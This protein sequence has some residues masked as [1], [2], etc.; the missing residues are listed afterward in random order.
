MQT[1]QTP[2]DAKI[3]LKSYDKHVKPTLEY[4]KEGLGKLF[5]AAMAKFPDRIGC[6]FMENEMTFR[7]LREKIHRFAT[8]LQQNG[9]GKGER[10]AINLPN[11]PQYLIAHFGTL[12]AGGVASGCSPLMSAS[13]IAYQI[14]DSEAKFFVTLDAFY[15]KVLYQV[16]GKMPGL[17][18]IITTNISE[19]MDLSKIL[20][21]LGKLLGKIPKGKVKPFPDKNVMDFMQ[22]MDTEINLTEVNIN[23]DNDLA[24]LQYTGGTT[25]LPKGTELTHSNIIS[26]IIQVMTWLDKQETN[27]GDV[28]LSAFPLFH[29]AGLAMS[30]ITLYTS[31]GQILI[32]NPRDTNHIIK[33][34]KENN[35]KIIVNVPTLYLAIKNNPKVKDI[36]K[37]TLENIDIYVS[38]AAPFPAEAI[39]DFE[40]SMDALNKVLEV[41]GMTETSPILTMN[42]YY[43]KKKIGTVGIPVPD[44]EIRLVDVETGEQVE[45]GKPGEVICR[46]PQVTRG[47]YNKPEANSKTIIDGWFHTGDVGVMDEDG[48]ITIVDRTKDMLIVSGFKVYS[49]HVEDIL[50]KHPDIEMVAI[51]GLKD[52]DRPGS[53]IVKAIVQLKEGIQ[54]SENIKEKLKKYATEHLSKYENPKIWEFR[55]SLPLTTVGKVLKRALRED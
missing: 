19:Y 11:C 35:P 31:T 15:E 42:P 6:Y 2:Y 5:D 37:S 28:N 8:F 47:Y 40:Q 14:N 53:E 45:L 39:N 43:G 38:G 32:A 7:E 50:T 36:T 1:Q 54:P 49:V 22:V 16:L 51:I 29:L 13:E 18:T 48:F 52:S 9:L 4:P 12:L 41:Y 20:V 3:W 46:G 55:E 34:I 10:V 17:N 44:T 33:E 23:V 24:L 30:M 26:N 21:F 25:G 27:E